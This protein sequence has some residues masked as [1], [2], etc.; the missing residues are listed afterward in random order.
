MR[1]YREESD[2]YGQSAAPIDMVRLENELS[3]CDEVPQLKT[4]ALTDPIIVYVGYKIVAVSAITMNNGSFNAQFKIFSSWVDP[5]VETLSQEECDIASRIHVR[6]DIST[7][8]MDY[9]LSRQIELLGLFSPGLLIVNANLLTL[10]S[11]SSKITNAKRGIV[12]MQQYYHGQLNMTNMKE[13]ALTSFPFDYHNLPVC[14]R[15]DKHDVT[16]A[17]LVLWRGMHTLEMDRSANEM[18]WTTIGHHNLELRTDP[19]FSS[20]AKV[21]S[22]FQISVMV[23][24]RVVWYMTHM[25]L[26]MIT[27]TFSSFAVI[28]I[29][30]NDISG[31]IEICTSLILALIA[32]SFVVSDHL[33]RVS[34]TTF[35]DDYTIMSFLLILAQVVCSA[36]LYMFIEDGYGTHGELDLDEGYEM[37]VGKEIWHKKYSRVT[38]YAIMVRSSATVCCLFAPAYTPLHI[39]PPDNILEILPKL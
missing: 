4:S 13:G 11:F 35:A 21:Y 18:E 16:K 1:S 9:Q 20:T 28:A 7:P 26:P 2:S 30:V 33:P 17:K 6:N 3:E 32:V 38:T 36:V 19:A 37:L 34:V 24:R 8:Q 25:A 14:I 23:Q 31:R 5:K 39:R 12:K 29:P 15:C 27:I 10:D 22:E